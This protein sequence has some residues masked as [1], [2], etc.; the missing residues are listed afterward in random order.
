MSEEKLSLSRQLDELKLE[1]RALENDRAKLE[2]FAGEI[3][4]RSVEIDELCKV[5]HLNS[6]IIT[7]WLCSINSLPWKLA[8]EE[9][10][11]CWRL[12]R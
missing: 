4:K 8:K 2:T 5:G 1:R 12:R 9:T 6:T 11:N 10:R 7:P 3:E